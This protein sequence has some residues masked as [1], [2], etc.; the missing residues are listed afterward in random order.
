MPA[1]KFFVLDRAEEAA[2][3]VLPQLGRLRGRHRELGDQAQR[4][5]TSVCLNL[6]E[7]RASGGK[8]QRNHLRIALGSSY[9]TTAALRLIRMQGLLPAQT[10]NDAIAKLDEVQAMTF[11]LM[12][13]I[14][15]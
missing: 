5:L 1:T 8:A 10:V 2:S 13:R 6:A 3:M 11:V 12:R 14:A 15:G 4:A 9:E 7:S